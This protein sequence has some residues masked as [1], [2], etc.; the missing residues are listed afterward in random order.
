MSDKI[1]YIPN[2]QEEIKNNKFTMISDSVLMDVG[3]KL[4]DKEYRVFLIIWKYTYGTS[5]RTWIAISQDKL[6]YWVNTTERTIRSVIKKLLEK[7]LIM[8]QTHKSQNNKWKYNSYRI[9]AGSINI[10]E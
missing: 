10:T 5:T 8:K 1:I 6:A 9:K 7:D 3:R 4:S 2:S